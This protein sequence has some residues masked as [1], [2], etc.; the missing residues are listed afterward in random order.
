M[1]V[2]PLL[3]LVSEGGNS[4]TFLWVAGGAAVVFFGFIAGDYLYHR[5]K[6]R[7]MLRQKKEPPA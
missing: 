7:Q 3:A 1:R 6:W 4:A 2:L 5:L